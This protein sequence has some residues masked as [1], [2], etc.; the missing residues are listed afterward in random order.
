MKNKVVLTILSLA[1]VLSA[2]ACGNASSDSE[3][4]SAVSTQLD[5]SGTEGS[6]LETEITEPA[7][8]EASDDVTENAED[9]EETVTE[10]ASGT[11]DD[12][13]EA[14]ET[15]DGT[16]EAEEVIPDISEITVESEDDGI[17]LLKSFFGTEDDETGN[18]YVFIYL[19]TV[20][21]DDVEYYAYTWSWAVDDHYSRLTDVFVS[22]D[23]SAI[24]EGDY[25]A[26]ECV[27]YTDNMLTE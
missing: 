14:V 12:A 17:T 8:T 16:E 11:E 27:F 22:L 25:D 15:S 20:T 21:I 2:A 10:E 4:D 23:G 5:Q 26:Q 1:L 18:Q 19:S 7:D 13:T 3:S 9:T 6:A 24:Y